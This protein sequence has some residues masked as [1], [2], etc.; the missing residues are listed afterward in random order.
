M[1]SVAHFP[2]FV[3]K[4]RSPRNQSAQPQ[5]QFDRCPTRATFVLLGLFACLTIDHKLASLMCCIAMRFLG[6]LSRPEEPVLMAK[7]RSAGS[8]SGGAVLRDAM[9][10]ISTTLVPTGWVYLCSCLL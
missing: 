5:P 6:F 1:L 4:H 9:P 2:S 8:S 3:I 10:P 7:H